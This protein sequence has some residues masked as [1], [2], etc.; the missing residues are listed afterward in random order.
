MP[1]RLGLLALAAAL[2]VAG[3]AETPAGPG[4][5]MSL[6][7]LAD[8]DQ[9][10]VTL[11]LSHFAAERVGVI[12]IV[13]V[14]SFRIEGRVPAC[15]TI[16]LPS[17]AALPRLRPAESGDFVVGPKQTITLTRLFRPVDEGKRAPAAGAVYTLV[18]RLDPVPNC[19][20]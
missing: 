15:S 8:W 14:S 1:S 16:F 19:K 20:D 2:V 4:D 3:P 10:T 18:D 5:R 13:N 11:D 7:S 9:V 17:D 12:R 6:V